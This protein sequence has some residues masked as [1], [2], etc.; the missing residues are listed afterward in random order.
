[1]QQGTVYSETVIHSAPARWAAEAPY[2][3]AVVDL[4]D[5]GRRL[6]RVQGERAKIG[7]QVSQVDGD[8]FEVKK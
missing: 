3:I 5:G 2:Q 6:V 7:D 1:M 4:Q 8:F